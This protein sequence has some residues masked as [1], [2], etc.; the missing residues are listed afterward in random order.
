MALLN[1]VIRNMLSILVCAFL[2]TGLMGC[3]E[4]SEEIVRPLP[5]EVINN[6]QGVGQALFRISQ[7]DG[8][9]DNIIDGGSCTSIIFPYTVIVNGIEVEI[10]SEDDLDFVEEIIDESESD[11]D[12]LV[13]IFPIQVALPDHT[14][15]SVF[16][17]DELEELTDECEEEG[18]DDDIECVDIVYPITFSVYNEATQNAQVIDIGN[19]A[20][21]YQFLENLT[22]EVIVSLNFPVVVVIPNGDR[23]TVE[24]NQQLEK[25]VEEY[26]DACDEDDDMDFDDDDMDDTEL[27]SILMNSAW[28]VTEYDSSGVNQTQ[29]LN[30]YDIEFL[31]NDLLVASVDTEEVTGDWYTSG[32]DNYLE[33]DLDFDTDGDLSLLNYEWVIIS[34]DETQIIIEGPGTESAISVTLTSK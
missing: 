32:N 9:E 10:N 25:V 4:E 20:E 5:S 12:S 13:I 16:S 28:T 17:M 11:V 27:R 14:I 15:I 21:L 18:F 22:E 3:Q 34:Y 33:L 29:R 2:L 30:S 1:S 31:T 8:S 7:N 23:V 24:N 6:N 19:D 26:E